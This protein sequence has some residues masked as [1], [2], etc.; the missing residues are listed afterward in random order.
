MGQAGFPSASNIN[1][2]LR[3]FVIKILKKTYFKRVCVCVLGEYVH[4]SAGALGS[5]RHWMGARVTGGCEA[6]DVCAGFSVGGWALKGGAISPGSA[7]FK[8]KFF[9]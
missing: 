2:L 5:Q 3:N 6:L 4:T 7:V 1:N 8:L 9:L